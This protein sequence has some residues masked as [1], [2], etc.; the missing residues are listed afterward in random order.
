M[1]PATSAT[2]HMIPSSPSPHD[3][4]LASHN[5]YSQAAATGRVF[6]TRDTRLAS[7]RD[8]VA[9]G[10]RTSF[11]SMG[12]PTPCVMRVRSQEWITLLQVHAH[13]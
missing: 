6:L 4:H 2:H 3:T 11:L 13:A 9:A 10:A 1:T 5:L 12:V 8:C 7:R